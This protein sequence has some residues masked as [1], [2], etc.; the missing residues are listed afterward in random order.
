[1]SLPHYLTH[2]RSRNHWWLQAQ[3]SRT[4]RY[5]S[6]KARGKSRYQL[7]L[8]MSIALIIFSLSLCF[9]FKG[10]PGN[11]ETLVAGG[12]ENRDET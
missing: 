7:L 5:R 9:L 10:T 8:E 6:R 12:R 4:L 1:M 2:P 11:L 3:Q